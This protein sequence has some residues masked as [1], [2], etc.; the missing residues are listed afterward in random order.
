M[1]MVSDLF[2][3]PQ[4]GAR[5]REVD[6][7]VVSTKVGIVGD[8]RYGLK[9]KPNTSDEWRPKGCFYVSMNTPNMA[10]VKP[11]FDRT[12]SGPDDVKELDQDYVREL[13]KRV[14][15]TK[16]LS[17]LDT[18]GLFNLT[19][20]DTSLPSVSLLNMASVRE[21]ARYVGTEIDPRR[22]RMNITIE[23]LKPLEETAWVTKYPGTRQ[24][25]IG[26]VRMQL[27]DMCERCQAIE[28]NPETGKRDIKLVPKLAQWLQNHGYKGSPHRGVHS[29]MGV[30]ARPLSAG[31]IT[32][33]DRI[34]L[35]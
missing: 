8:R 17:I 14:G 22:F 27:E 11:I 29:V 34:R 35:L 19:D 24:I 31:I 6:Y 5:G 7:L 18:K 21:F 1:A 12:R 2:T 9:K 23:G 10:C 13:S 4:K 26:D 30:I 25:M 28:A 20:C 16:T 3:Y 15:S 32:A 33:D